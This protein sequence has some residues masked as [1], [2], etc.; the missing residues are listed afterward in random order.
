[1]T[2][3]SHSQVSIRRLI[4]PFE[5]HF[6]IIGLLLTSPKPVIWALMPPSTNAASTLPLATCS[7]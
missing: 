7:G 6:N 5:K 4:S 3:V 1:M 2:D